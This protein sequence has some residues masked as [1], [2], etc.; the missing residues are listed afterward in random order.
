MKST[1]VLPTKENIYNSIQQDIIGRNKQVYYFTSMLN[2]VEGPYSFALNARWGEG[3][4]FF[5]KQTQMFLD[6]CNPIS[7]SLSDEEKIVVKEAMQRAIGGRET[8]TDL[9]PQMTIY[10]DAWQCDNDTDPILSLLYEITR[11][12]AK[13]FK[14]DSED[15]RSKLLNALNLCASIADLI[16]GMNSKGVVSAIK[17]LTKKED[18]MC[19]IIQAKDLQGSII[20]FLATIMI[21][22]GNRLVIFID[23]LDRCKPDYAVRFLERIKHYFVIENV[24]FVFSVNTQELQHTI[25]RYYGDKFSATL[26]LTRFFDFIVDLPAAELRSFYDTLGINTMYHFDVVCQEVIN[27][28]HFSLRDLAQYYKKCRIAAHKLTHDNASYYDKGEDYGLYALVPIMIGLEIYDYSAYQM[29]VDGKDPSPLIEILGE[30]EILSF[31]FR[32]M[33]SNDET[34][35]DS[36]SGKTYVS[37]KQKLEEYYNAVFAQD[38]DK[39]IYVK[40]IGTIECNKGTKLF[41]LQVASGLTPYADRT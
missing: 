28:Y 2:D 30:G 35:D 24:T 40:R 18:P 36:E 11:Q 15:G 27:Y 23:E 22:Q 10:Y 32:A 12:C 8:I 17:D 33:L 39:R 14:Y 31:L 41:L 29:F 37:K 9:Q 25:N 4:T 34:Y 1:Q 5:I 38:Y 13:C 3:K 16:P 20:D 6:A 7:K 26:Y 19:E 21:E